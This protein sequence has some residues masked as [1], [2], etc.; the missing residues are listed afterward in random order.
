M[1]NLKKLESLVPEGLRIH[2]NFARSHMALE[3]Q[4]PALRADI[5]KPPREIKN[6][7]AYL[8]VKAVEH[9]RSQRLM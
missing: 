9:W 7:W 6:K 2:Y 5:D 8:L 4:I 1:R 3:G